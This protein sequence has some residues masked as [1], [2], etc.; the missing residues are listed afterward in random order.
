MTKKSGRPG[1]NAQLAKSGSL[2]A[3]IPCTGDR[4]IFFR[5][6]ECRNFEPRRV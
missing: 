1:I 4:A 6:E 5:E 2:I 3:R